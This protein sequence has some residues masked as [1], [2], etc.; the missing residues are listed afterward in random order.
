MGK[1]LTVTGLKNSTDF[2]DAYGLF[3]TLVPLQRDQEVRQKPSAHRRHFRTDGIGQGEPTVGHSIDF[4]Q[5][6]IEVKTVG[7]NFV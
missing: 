7:Q 2:E 3:S 4:F 6:R 1:F 5:E